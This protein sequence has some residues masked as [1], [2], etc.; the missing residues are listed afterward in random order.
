MAD[1]RGVALAP[2]APGQRS[3]GRES[4]ADLARGVLQQCVPVAEPRRQQVRRLLRHQWPGHALQLRQVGH[5]EVLAQ[6]DLCR[7]GQPAGDARVHGQPPGTHDAVAHRSGVGVRVP[8][9]RGRR[10]FQQ[11]RGVV[12]R[13]QALEQVPPAVQ[14]Q[15]AR[16]QLGVEQVLL[17]EGLAGEQQVA[18]LLLTRSEGV[19]AVA[20][21]RFRLAADHARVCRPQAVF[22][23]ID[24]C[25]RAVGGD[26]PRGAGRAAGR[27]ARR[28]LMA[29]RVAFGQRPQ[30]APGNAAVAVADHQVLGRHRGAV[31]GGQRLVQA[32]RCCQ[33][34][35]AEVHRAGQVRHPAQAQRPAI[36]PLLHQ[37]APSGLLDHELHVIAARHRDPLDV[38]GHRLAVAVRCPVRARCFQPPVHVVAVA[39]GEPPRH[40]PVAAHD[41]R[42]HAGQGEAGHVHPA[43]GRAGLRIAQPRPEPHVGRA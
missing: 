36:F 40:V 11:R 24:H 30:Q 9:R 20:H 31:G 23:R 2:G 17:G 28:K 32:A 26:R 39:V 18:D 21:Q 6:C 12:A 35:Q 33:T 42:R 22:R 14:Q 15:G 10:K 16:V 3:V 27:V 43:A 34:G 7:T 8:V 5:G 38:P 19:A 25:R 37:R 13:R 29:G 41:H 1:A 4:V